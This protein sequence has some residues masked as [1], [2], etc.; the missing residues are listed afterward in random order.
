MA[1]NQPPPRAVDLNATL[2]ELQKIFRTVV[3]ER[4]TLRTELDPE[5]GLIQGE[6]R[7]IASMMVN[8]LIEARDAT[9][10]G[11]E[12]LIT[13]SNLDLDAAGAG[14]WGL[15]PGRYVGLRIELG[16]EI[17]IAKTSEAAGSLGGGVE[18]VRSKDGFAITV[19]L[20]RWE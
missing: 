2:A 16:R 11:G 3:G 14:R 5:L 8:L 9:K 15:G 4:I 18:A 20:P 17:Q 13:T 10:P 19:A 1:C 6:S 12:L 7:R